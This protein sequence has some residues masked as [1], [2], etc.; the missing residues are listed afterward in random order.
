MKTRWVLLGGMLLTLTPAIAAAQSA[1][2]GRGRM[3]YEN[4]CTTCHTSTAH[5]RTDHK[6]LSIDDIRRQ[7]R[8]WADE[9]G[10]GWDDEDVAA[11]T[12]YLNTQYYHY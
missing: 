5:V 11:V 3:L 4:H 6:A 1:D 10:L 7:V 8:R 2:T 12:S 9:K